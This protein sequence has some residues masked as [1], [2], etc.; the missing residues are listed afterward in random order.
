[1]PWLEYPIIFDRSDQPEHL[2]D[3]GRFP[4]VV[5]AV[6]ESV[7]ATKVSMDGGSDSSLLY[8]DTF[9][10][11]KIGTD[12]LHPTRGP[13][14]GVVPRRQVMPLGVIDLRVTFSDVVNYC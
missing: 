11:L 3:V 5:S 7:R 8:W 6:I 13:I 4:L 1:M 14:S 2:V 12:K 9:E 10:I